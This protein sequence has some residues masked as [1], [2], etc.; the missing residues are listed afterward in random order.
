MDVLVAEG[1]GKRY[2]LDRVKSPGRTVS[3]PKPRW[4]LSLFG[5]KRELRATRELWALRD[6]SFSVE[7]GTVL[8]VIGPNGAGKSTLLKVIGRITSPTEG[9][10]IGRGRVVSLIEL[11]AGFNPDLSGRDN[12]FM[13]AAMHGVSNAEVRSRLDE[14][15][16][17]AEMERFLDS[18]VKR[19]SSGMFLRL[20]FSVAI[21][22][23]PSI[24][25]ADE[26]LAVGD[27]AF[28]LRCW[29]KVEEESHRGLTVLFVSHDLAAVR[30]LCHQVLWLDEGRI[31]GFGATEELVSAYQ[32]AARSQ[33][34]GRKTPEEVAA[35]ELRQRAN[36]VVEIL[37]VQLIT[38]T[39]GLLS[40][41][42]LSDPV[43]V[44]VRVRV[45][46]GG[47]R[48]RCTIDL[49]AK[50]VLIL[51]AVQ[52]EYL[53]ERTATYDLVAHLP[54][55]FLAE[56]KYSIDVFIATSN[57]KPGS[58]AVSNAL[59]FLGYGGADDSEYNGGVLAP[60]LDWTV[61]K[62]KKKRLRLSPS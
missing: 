17:F 32:A 57:G 36:R 6:V 15:V 49:L 20:A 12:V 34:L 33:V 3:S 60:R 61:H 26:I 42:A 50:G 40:A 35:A 4:P 56:T 46:R 51:R 24:L 55:H 1:L 45:F 14:I 59:T 11:G 7:Q 10:V 9:R 21:H 23:Q 29:Q 8:G 43:A 47:V 30:R 62:V 39:G 22:L 38:P 41:A 5:Q 31:A 16:A 18:P 54:A 28:Q 2:Y 27:L 52:P 19:Y 13:N 58:V 53:A 48:L 25:L 44:R 37:S